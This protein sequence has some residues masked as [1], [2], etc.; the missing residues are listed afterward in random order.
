MTYSYQT[1][2][3]SDKLDD[4][5]E[6]IDKAENL[7][8]CEIERSGD[9]FNIPYESIHRAA[10]LISCTANQIEYKIQRKSNKCI[11]HPIE[12]DKESICDLYNVQLKSVSQKSNYKEN[13]QRIIDCLRQFESEVRNAVQNADDSK[14]E[15][16][17]D[18]ETMS[19]PYME[20]DNLLDNKHN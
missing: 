11:S 14:C 19:E 20:T 12:V 2:S 10:W 5:V 1:K 15:P 4:A 9:Y 18:L 3:A 13:T 8:R 7:M 16:E 17:K 6:L